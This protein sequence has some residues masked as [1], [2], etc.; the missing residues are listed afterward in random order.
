MC[1]KNIY[2]CSTVKIHLINI[3]AQFKTRYLVFLNK[4]NKLVYFILFI[5]YLN[6]YGQF[7]LQSYGTRT[8]SNY[9]SYL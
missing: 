9:F 4:R 6:L 3:L 2:D 8:Y 1:S 7:K 5:L